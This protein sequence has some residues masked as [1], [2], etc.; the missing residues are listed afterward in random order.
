MKADYVPGRRNLGPDEVRRR[1]RLGIIGAASS[2]LLFLLLLWSDAPRPTRVLLALPI[3][4]A[5]LGFVQAATE[6]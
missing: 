5:A 6:T 3:L 4:A 1:R 2:I